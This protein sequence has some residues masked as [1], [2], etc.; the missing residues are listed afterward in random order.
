M[1]EHE[2]NAAQW[3]VD[4]HVD[5]GRGDDVALRCQGRSTTYAELQRELWRVQRLLP[6]LAVGSGDRVA[7]VVRDDEAF[8]AFFLGA[9]RSGAVPVPL[10]TMSRGGALAEVVADCGARALVVSD[11]FG[12][13]VPDVVAGAPALEHV[14]VCGDAAAVPAGAGAVEVHA[15]SDRTAADELGVAATSTDSPAFWL[16]SSGTTG[17]PKG[18]M[19]RHGNL[20]ATYDTYAR[21]VLEVSAEDRFLSVAKL[22]FAFGLGNSLTFP[23]AAGAT[24]IL[25]PDPPAP[26]AV[27][28]LVR[29]EAPTLFFSSPGFC[30]ALLDAS[31]DPATFASVRATVTAGEALPASLQVR[32]AELSGAPVLDGI[33]TTEL[34][35]IFISNTLDEQ[36]PGT[37]G[38]VVPGYRAELRGDDDR[39]VTE[40]D[41][42]G[43]LHVLGPSAATGYW[44]RP[45]ATA[46]AFLDGGWVRTGDV[47][48]RSAD[49]HW[50]FLGR[51]NDMIKAGGIWVSPAEVENVL[52]GHPSVLE[53]AVVGTRD[54]AGLETVVAFVVPAAGA[55]PDP[56]VLQQHCRA[57]LEA[58][59]RP[60]R[61]VVTDGLPKTATGKIKRFE[62]R[63]LLEG[64][65]V[66][67]R[68]GT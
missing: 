55:E 26:A 17:R 16:Y 67:P 29:D 53:A 61:I 9:L 20:P 10:S 32:F 5:E 64:D 14:V 13:V 41:T 27:A 45:E 22:F 12:A 6:D 18:V 15:W 7:M 31:L 30:A 28:A 38:R 19:H 57:Q 24:S 50:T 40:P 39:V 3:L 21:Q 59:K 35:H 8:P 49:D 62:L 23:L 4:R 2:F 52:I 36:V 54:T 48:T 25:N 1:S 43:F 34:L 66:T 58:F 65:A 60:R 63:S 37:S 42:P 51:N 68:R 44:E 47:Y 11:V 33:G 46:A 56:E